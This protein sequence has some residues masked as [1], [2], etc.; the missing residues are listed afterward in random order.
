[1][2]LGVIACLVGAA[3][4]IPVTAWADG[5]R[6]GGARQLV[7]TDDQPLGAVGST[8][9]FTKS[10]PQT[11]SP[12]DTVL[13]SST[14]TASFQF[15]T[16]SRNGGDG[17]AFAVA[18]AADYFVIRN[19]SVGANVLFGLLNPAPGPRQ[20]AIEPPPLPGAAPG[21]ATSPPSWRLSETVFGIAA[22]V[23]Y[24]LTLTDTISFWPNL[25]F[26]YIEIST[27]TSGSA[28]GFPSSGSNAIAIG[29]YVP[30]MFQL[31][32]HFLLGIGPN[33]STQLSNNQTSGSTAIFETSGLSQP[34]VTQVGVQATIGGWFLGD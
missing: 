1:M 12:S 4:S 7:I 16:L 28:N 26:G 23:G 24:N 27:T 11:G 30:I 14:S 32:T 34:L 19:L 29:Y 33:F 22:R 25:Y 21:A 15:A 18:P 6:F 2:R 9:L 31:A 20:P 17:T 5:P 10:S 13:P 8:G 3:L